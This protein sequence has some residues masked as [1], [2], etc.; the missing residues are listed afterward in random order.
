VR[1]LP[2][3]PGTHH[4]RSRVGDVSSCATFL[5]SARSYAFPT[6]G[7]QRAR[8][9]AALPDDAPEPGRG[10]DAEG[11]ADGRAQQRQA[12]EQYC[13]LRAGGRTMHTEVAGRCCPSSTSLCS[14]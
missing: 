5:S 1:R 4:R 14:F 8:R 7:P 2:V 3:R 12:A 10:D 13:N 11:R 6:G 9:P